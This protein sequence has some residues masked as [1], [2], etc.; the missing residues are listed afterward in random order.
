M[1]IMDSDLQH[2]PELIPNLI[3]ELAL[4]ASFGCC[5]SIRA[6]RRP[7]STP[8]RARRDLSGGGM[9]SEIHAPQR[10]TGHG[11]GVGILRVSGGRFLSTSTRST[12]AINYCCSSW[13]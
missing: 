2:P 13:S 10:P 9:D 11:P 3:H 7:G 5:E 1:V 4:G 12:G 6:G 8:T